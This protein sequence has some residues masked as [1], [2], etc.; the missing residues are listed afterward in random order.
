VVVTTPD[1]SPSDAECDQLVAHALTLELADRPADQQL[2]DPERDKVLAQAR[3]AQRPAC[4]ALS[5]DAYRCMAA[6][7]TSG[8][9]ARCN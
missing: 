6:A 5:R 3:E 8:D 7:T 9:L 1:A 4:R 2:G